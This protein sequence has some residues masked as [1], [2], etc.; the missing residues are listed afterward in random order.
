[1][2]FMP[3]GVHLRFALTDPPLPPLQP[4]QRDAISG[5][6]AGPEVPR[7]RTPVPASALLG[8][9]GGRGLARRAAAQARYVGGL[10][11]SVAH[12]EPACCGDC[13]CACAAKT[14]RGGPRGG[15][16][17]GTKNMAHNTKKA[18]QIYREHN[19]GIPTDLRKEHTN[20]QGT[21]IHARQCYMRVRGV[22]L[23]V[24]AW[25]PSTFRLPSTINDNI[26]ALGINV[27]SVLALP[28]SFVVQ[29]Y[30]SPVRHARVCVRAAG[31]SMLCSGCEEART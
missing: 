24:D 10:V 1:M 7:A 30:E 3:D 13:C 4:S 18:S 19:L 20:T 28:L 9:R 12:R 31:D 2:Y 8:G 14:R 23:G 25:L 21:A 15:S 16:H 11:L 17:G 26:S 29:F 22:A 5:H 27:S 6:P